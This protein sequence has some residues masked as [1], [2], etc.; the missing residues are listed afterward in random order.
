MIKG[1]SVDHTDCATV[2]KINYFSAELKS[3]IRNRLSAICHGPEAVEN[4]RIFASYKNTLKEFNKRYG[5]KT[6]KIKKGMIGELLTHILLFETHP[7]Y[8]PFN[9]FFNME[10]A[11]IKK[12]FDLV[13]FDSSS[14]MLWI[15]EVKSGNAGVKEAN[16]FNKTLLNTAKGDLKERLK[17][18]ETNLWHNA[19]NGAKL[20]LLTGRVKDRINQILEECYQE[21]ADGRQDG[22]SKNVILISVTYKSTNDPITI[23]NVNQK[24]CSIKNEFIFN[25]VVVFSIQKETYQRVADFLTHEA[26]L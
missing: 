18:N 22:F 4:E 15:S 1:V 14:N 12:G 5:S 11:S 23:D 20:A 25:E 6:D 13:V 21:A 19:I 7:N 17:D 3:A 9:P 8:Q 24:A 2:C 26:G 10:E 16:K